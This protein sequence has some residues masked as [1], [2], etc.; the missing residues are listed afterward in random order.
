MGALTIMSKHDYNDSIRY[1][2]A[3]R[4]FI[5]EYYKIY[6]PADD[7]IPS[8]LSNL[9]RVR[10]DHHISLDPALWAMWEEAVTKVR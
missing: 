10:L 1:F 4:Y 9:G 6:G 8:L 5:E 3:L 7:R 2:V